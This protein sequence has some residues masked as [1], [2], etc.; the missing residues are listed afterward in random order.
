MTEEY[1]L[2]DGDGYIWQY[3]H[4]YWCCV[5]A[6]DE[7]RENW[8]TPQPGDESAYE[9]FD[10]WKSVVAAHGISASVACIESARVPDESAE[11]LRRAAEA[12]RFDAPDQ[13]G[14][15]SL[16]PDDFGPAVADLLDTCAKSY[17]PDF[18]SL[19]HDGAFAVARAYLGEA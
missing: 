4:G 1:T 2:V 16:L 10:S 15:W 8:S 9:G 17:H 11:T 7:E 6:P 18:P 14:P 13:T 19:R 5:V 12:I 3:A